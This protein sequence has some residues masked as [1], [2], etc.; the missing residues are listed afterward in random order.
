M[1]LMKD[2]SLNWL[3]IDS[4]LIPPLFHFGHLR[5]IAKIF[6]VVEMALSSMVVVGTFILV[7][8]RLLE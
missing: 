1:G 7:F 3:P 5:G 6:V 8:L 4:R 2:K